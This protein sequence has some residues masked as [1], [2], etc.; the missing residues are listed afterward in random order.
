MVRTV[1]NLQPS[2]NSRLVIVVYLN[3]VVAFLREALTSGPLLVREIER[4]AVDAGLFEKGKSI[5][6][7]KT[8]RTA[9]L[10]HGL[11]TYQLPGK[12]A[13]GWI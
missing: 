2:L 3:T 12:R 5:G 7:S 6:E 1:G 11:K 10:A 4:R 13:G 8:F 9:R